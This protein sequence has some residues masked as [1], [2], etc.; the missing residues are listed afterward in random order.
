MVAEGGLDEEELAVFT[1]YEWLASP[2]CA[3][4]G[5]LFTAYDGVAGAEVGFPFE[6]ELAGGGVAVVV[7]L[8]VAEVGSY[9]WLDLC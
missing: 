3:T 1:D 7:P 9:E 8:L 5:F 2:A 6:V 4:P